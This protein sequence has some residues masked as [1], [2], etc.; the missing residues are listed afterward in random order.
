MKSLLSVAAL[1]SLGAC[2]NLTSL[3]NVAGNWTCPRV[4]G[5]CAD[6]ATI[7]GG[8]N[9]VIP[10]AG[11]AGRSIGAE[12]IQIA[13]EQGLDLTRTPDQVAKIVFAPSLDGEGHYHSARAIYAVMAPGDWVATPSP[14]L[15]HDLQTAGSDNFDAL[16]E[17]MA[18]LAERAASEELPQ[19]V[20]RYSRTVSADLTDE[21]Q[22]Q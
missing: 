13:V 20:V 3:D 15:A 21:A 17:T 8:L 19:R 4:D 9:G 5:V 7:D 2:T 22:D 14:E 16:G 12:A 1:M 18:G 6:I 10:A 11:A